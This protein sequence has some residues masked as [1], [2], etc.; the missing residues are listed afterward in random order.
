MPC[1]QIDPSWDQGRRREGGGLEQGEGQADQE[2]Q[3]GG[4][5]VEEHGRLRYGVHGRG[6]RGGG[7]TGKGDDQQLGCFVFLL[8]DDRVMR[9]GITRSVT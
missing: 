1:G 6:G 5:E 7:N 8:S 3:G 9:R 4:R 2:G